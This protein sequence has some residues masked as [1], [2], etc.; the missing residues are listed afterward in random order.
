MSFRPGSAVRLATFALVLALSGAVVAGCSGSGEATADS[1]QEAFDRAQDAL[2]RRKY[3]RAVELFRTTLDFGRTGEIADDAQLGLARAYAGSREYLLAGAEFT[4]FIDLYRADPRV[5]EAAYERIQSYAAL[6]PTYE[7]DQTDTATA[8]SYIEGFLSQYPTSPRAPA[9]QALLAEMREKLAR[10][11][12]EEGRLYER[13]DLF[14][15]AVISYRGV[16]DQY[17]TSV[18]ADDA[19]FG[20]VRAQVRLADNSVAAR[21]EARYREA[22]RLYDQLVSLFPQ[23][24]TLAEAQAEY[25]RAYRGVQAAGGVLE[26]RATA[27]TA[28]Q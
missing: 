9:A 24:P 14:E 7:L 26:A 4:R 10:K 1:A 23:S 18:Y 2:T 21:Q 8:M 22:L 20:A 3:D 25:D 13:R 28:G 12:Y 5:E 17:P 6:S 16:L 15:A 27:P 11:Q 19:L